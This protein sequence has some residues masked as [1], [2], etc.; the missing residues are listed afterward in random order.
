M[1]CDCLVNLCCRYQKHG[2]K[3]S[4]IFESNL[5][6]PLTVF[7]RFIDL[8][9]NKHVS[10]DTSLPRNLNAYCFA[11]KEYAD[12]LKWF[13]QKYGI[14]C[15][16]VLLENFYGADEPKD[17]FIPSTIIKITKYNMY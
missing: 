7:S 4:E 9:I 8:G 16:N 15:I 5:I 12:I 2:I 13:S 6:V 11:K 10:I 1:V 14:N 3:D 17:S